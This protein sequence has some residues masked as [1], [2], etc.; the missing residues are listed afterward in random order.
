MTTIYVQPSKAGGGGTFLN[1]LS[2]SWRAGGQ[3]VTR[4]LRSGWDVGLVNVVLDMNEQRFLLRERRP[5]VL[6]LDGASPRL[7]RFSAL[8]LH[9]RAFASYLQCRGIIFQS[10]TSQDDWCR[11]LPGGRKRTIIYNGIR[12]AGVPEWRPVGPISRSAIR[13]VAP[14]LLRYEY[15]VAPFLSFLDEE[16]ARGNE[17][18][19]TIL[20]PVAD[21]LLSRLEGHGQ[22]ELAGPIPAKE[23]LNRLVEH[24]FFVFLNR[25]APCPNSVIEAMSTGMPMLLPRVGSIPELAGEAYPVFDL[26]AP[27]V[28]SRMSK[29]VDRIFQDL[30]GSEPQLGRNARQRVVERFD[31]DRIAAQYRDFLE[32]CV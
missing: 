16:T 11:R 28:G 13:F 19:L 20:G 27:D 25:F 5:I 24:D 23:V 7:F 30:E 18:R 29:T 2:E 12:P 1:R 10:R 6:R 15:Q 3:A 32:S 31:I 14:I 9:T 17:H 8:K 22:I 4:D 26:D 21:A